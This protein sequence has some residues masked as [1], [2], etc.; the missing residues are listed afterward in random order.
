MFVYA[1]LMMA[2]LFV[3]KHFLDG[4]QSVEQQQ[5]E[6]AEKLSKSV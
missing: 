2:A 5:A 1:Y 6:K 4:R 3:I